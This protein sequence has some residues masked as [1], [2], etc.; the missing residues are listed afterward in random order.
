MVILS[1][2]WWTAMLLTTMGSEYWPRTPE[3]RVLCLL[4]ALYAF[5]VF[6]Y[7]TAAIAAY[8]PLLVA[9]RRA[10]AP[11]LDLGA[12][13]LRRQ[14]LL[15]GTLRRLRRRSRARSHRRLLQKSREAST[16]RLAVHRLR[17][18]LATVDHEHIAGR[19]PL[20]GERSQARLDMLRQ[21]GGPDGE[22]QLHRGRHLVDVL[23]AWSGRADEA[24]LDFM[25]RDGPSHA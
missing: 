22:A 19:H 6:G 4:L 12:G 7:V 2:V 14:A 25:G 5:A 15:A 11:V 20:A 10:A 16:R 21:R 18:M 23:P 3:G 24:L 9:V 13:L 8:D 1:A 17:P